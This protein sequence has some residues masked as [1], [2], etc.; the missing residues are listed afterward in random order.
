[1][2]MSVLLQVSRKARCHAH[3]GL[4]AQSLRSYGHV[5]RIDVT[6]S[7]RPVAWDA[8]NTRVL[9]P[10]V[11]VR[12]RDVSPMIVHLLLVATTMF[13]FWDLYLLAV[14]APR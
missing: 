14:H 1:M 10:S 11:R 9:G 7:L 3:P 2:V 13:M 8:R 6:G 5:R 4:G 12:R